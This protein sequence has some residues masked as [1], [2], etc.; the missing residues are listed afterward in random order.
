MTREF[1]SNNNRPETT[2]E[3][4]KAKFERPEVISMLTR[5]F[6]EMVEMGILDA[7]RSSVL[8]DIAPIT[9][10]IK[11]IALKIMSP[12]DI[13]KVEARKKV[14][15][16]FILSAIGMEAPLLVGMDNSVDISKGLGDEYKEFSATRYFLQKY[17]IACGEPEVY[18]SVDVAVIHEAQPLV[19]APFTE[20]QFSIIESHYREQVDKGI[21]ISK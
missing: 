19:H 2:P 16:P 6:K 4:L 10:D 15:E 21:V 5:H 8:Q 12:E 1:A 11:D 14:H 18:S 9:D 20:E 17:D 3:E 13:A 7:Y